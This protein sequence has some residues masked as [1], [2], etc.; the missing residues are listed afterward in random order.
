MNAIQ[1][2][3]RVGEL[4]TERIKHE[5]TWAE[6][7]RYGAPERQQSFQDAAQNGLEDIR[8]Q[9]RSKL[10]DT[11]AAEAIQLFVSSIISATTPA[12]KLVSGI[13]EVVVPAAL[14]APVRWHSRSSSFSW[15]IYKSFRTY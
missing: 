5:P 12:S 11:T 15:I 1:L 4:K 9:E 13:A 10:F 3:K 7:Y 2:I 8:R 14:T 6:L